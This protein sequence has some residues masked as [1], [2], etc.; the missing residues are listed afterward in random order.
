M[1]KR[2]LPIPAIHV[3]P[4]LERELNANPYNVNPALVAKLNVCQKLP[5]FAAMYDT[6]TGELG[7]VE[8]PP[9]ISKVWAG[10]PD[11]PRDLAELASLVRRKQPRLSALARLL[12]LLHKEGEVTFDAAREKVH[13][14]DVGEDAIEA[15]V[16]LARRWI[17]K[18]EL[19]FKV[20]ISKFHITSLRK[21]Q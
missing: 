19:P 1:A 20:S 10:N 21:P 7:V 12:D 3:P 15:K 18:Y 17:R 8:V 5:G 2:L 16:K 14:A 11:E 6:E 13:E 4:E 9:E